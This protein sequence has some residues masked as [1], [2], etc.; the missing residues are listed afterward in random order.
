MIGLFANSGDLDQMLQNTASD[1]GL[2]CLPITLLQ[3]VKHAGIHLKDIF[4]A[5]VRF[6]DLGIIFKVSVIAR[7][8]C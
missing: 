2:H 5:Q 8:Q 6:G 3:W 7:L 4:R 1:L